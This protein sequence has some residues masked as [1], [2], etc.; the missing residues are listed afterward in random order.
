MKHKKAKKPKSLKRSLI[1]LGI[2]LCVIAVLFTSAYYI[3][4]VNTWSDLTPEKIT[5]VQESLRIYDKNGKL[6]SLLNAGENR[7]KIEIETLPDYV[8]YAFISAEDARF[9]SH[10]GVDIKRIFGALL[11]DLKAGYFKEGASTITQQL[12]KNSHLTNA[13]TLPRKLQE[14]VLAYQ[15]EQKY[16]K[17]EILEMYLNYIYFGNRAY[18]IE[19]A[20][21][22]Y[23][24]K[25]ASELTLAEA[26]LLA[27]VIKSPSKYA[28][29]IQPENAVG[30]RNLILGLM[31]E[32]G[33]ISEE[34]R[35]TA[36]QEE[37]KL[38]EN[39]AYEIS[40]GYYIDMLLEESAQALNM[41]IEELLCSG[42]SIYSNLDSSLQ[43]YLE[44]VYADSTNF[45]EGDGDT[46]P[47]S[48]A[49]II[50]NKTGGIAAVM[51]GR[52]YN[53]RFCLN[54]AYMMKRSP[55]STIKPI[56]VYAPAFENGLLSP[57]SVLID[58]RK[59]FD[60]YS[61]R[62]FNDKYY[63]SITVR[64]A[65]IKSLNVPAVETLDMVGIE[66]A[67]KYAEN[68][69]ISF[70]K[71]DKNLALALGGFTYGISPLELAGAYQAL[72]NN[73][74]QLDT[75]CIIRMCDDNGKEIYE[76][77]KNAHQAI[78]RETAFMLSDI[79]EDAAEYGSTAINLNLSIPVSVKT[80][81]VGYT[82]ADGYS[83]SWTAAYNSDYTIV[84]WL[85][86]DKTTPEHYL[87]NGITGGT[88][89]AKIAGKLFNYL[90]SSQQAPEFIPP[91]TVVSLEI[92]TLTLKNDGVI[93]CATKDTPEIYRMTDYFNIKY[94]PSQTSQYWTEPA[95]PE[96]LS[97]Y[98]NE[99]RQPVISFNS[100]ASYVKYKLYRV[101]QSTHTL[102]GW[103]MGESGKTLS[104][105]DSTA[106]SGEHSYY[107]LPEHNDAYR[108]GLPLTGKISQIVNIS[109]P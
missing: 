94:A 69:G 72:G 16:E 70:D 18:G 31:C 1:K 67:K 105:T 93:T 63:G 76:P 66:N 38:H 53:T 58:E 39:P 77:P 4:G 21:Q 33:Y 106:D 6:I 97:C 36:R 50:D 37:L 43:G 103:V 12:V 51:G 79:L 73:G 75:S 28:P 25:G 34:E 64:E 92:D 68:L 20:A 17:D 44:E 109:V 30:R 100:Q 88:Y 78:S 42:Y 74:M 14:A 10:Q 48:A 47:Q 9:Y 19:S 71:Q 95:P 7:T 3:L 61:P 102:I 107:I 108:H 15:L 26:A 101:E 56:M 52:S 81:T 13:K 24:N 91:E 82:G 98:L 29:H 86:Y 104:I 23:F 5:D 2:C 99:L 32:Y 90:Y 65:L 45:P 41:E 60:G 11:A 35:D 46:Q 84:V 85:G 40:Y 89:P 55:G 59:S 87:K 22:T 96:E 8:K 57:A 49:V 83:D 27:G 80:G 62:N 54:R